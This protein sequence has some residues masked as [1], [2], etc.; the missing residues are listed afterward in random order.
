MKRVLN[1][2]VCLCMVLS[3][4]ICAVCL[5][6]AATDDE[7]G[8]NM[9]KNKADQFVKEKGLTEEVFAVYFCDLDRREEYVFNENAF[10]PV[11]TNWILPLHMHYYEQETLGAFN[12]PKDLP[13][14]IYTIGGMTLERCRYLSILMSDEEVSRQMR[15]NLGSVEQ[16]LLLINEEYGHIDP[17]T[18]PD[19]YFRNNCYSAAFLMNCLKRIS[20]YPELYQDMMKNFSLVQ[21]DDGFAAYDRPYNLVHLRGEQDGFICDLA[22]V[23]GPDNY[24]LVCFASED[25]GGDSLLAEVNSLFCNYVEQANDIQQNTAPTGGDRQRSDLD[26]HVAS[27][28]KYQVNKRNMVN[29]IVIALAGGGVAA[30]IICLII[31]LL[32]RRD[33]RKWEAQSVKRWEE[34]G[35]KSL[36]AHAVKRLGASEAKHHDEHEAK[37][38]GEHGAKHRDASEKTKEQKK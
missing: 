14:E 23:S 3:I 5:P 28:D 10:L 19:E 30:A 12:P 31:F 2:C 17:D 22:E 18:L 27:L 16:Y 8:L 34:A 6:I 15:D 20:T 11:G 24:L 7:N 37:H 35:D 1:L 25:A 38:H 32:R 36:D 4:L 33:A 13:D 29:W 21:T 26:F 9:L